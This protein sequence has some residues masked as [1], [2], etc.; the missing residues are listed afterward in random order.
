MRR[1]LQVLSGHLSYANVVA[2][3]A[4]FIAL[5][6][7]SYAAV[8]LPR[9][10]VGTA[11]LKKNAVTATKVRNGAITGAKMKPGTITAKRIKRGAITRRELNLGKLGALPD[12]ARLGGLPAG[13]FARAGAQAPDAAALGGVPAGSYFRVGGTLPRGATVSGAFGGLVNPA[14]RYDLIVSLPAPSPTPIATENVKF[15]PGS[16]SAPSDRID[17][18]CSGT[19]EQPVAPAG[20]VCLYLGQIGVDTEA[21]IGLVSG[22][23]GRRGFTVRTTADPDPLTLPGFQ[24]AAGT[25]AYTV[26]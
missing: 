3:L 9:N 2:T 18:S 22:Q 19:T 1:R 21:I 15:A 25:W 17:P 6:G 14:L 10:S 7:A 8:T 20:T 12:A 16:V 11:Q 5:G 13:A 24:G 26:P 23:D 4:L